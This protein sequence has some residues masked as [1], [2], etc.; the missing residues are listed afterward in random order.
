MESVGVP[1]ETVV[2]LEIGVGQR[3]LDAL[4]LIAKQTKIVKR[5]EPGI[6]VQVGVVVLKRK[7]EIILIG[8]K[9][10][11]DA[12]ILNSRIWFKNFNYF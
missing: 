11:M 4:N 10:L 8:V 6:I 5:T 7:Q 12:N 2:A 1:V 3:P 9:R